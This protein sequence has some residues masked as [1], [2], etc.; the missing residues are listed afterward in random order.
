MKVSAGSA[1]ARTLKAASFPDQRAQSRT[2]FPEINTQDFHPVKIFHEAAHP[3]GEVFHVDPSRPGTAAFGEHQDRVPRIEQVMACV[4]GPPHFLAIA[5]SRDG[6][7]LRQVADGRLDGVAVE[8]A[9]LGEVPGQPPVLEQVAP[10][11]QHGIAEEHGVDQRQVICADEPASPVLPEMVQA[12]LP[13]RS[14]VAKPVAHQPDYD[15][16]DRDVDERSQMAQYGSG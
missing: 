15:A 3:V 6:D 2:S 13:E 8:V 4:E 10:V 16:D 12:L 5:S 9:A 11:R 14:E 1:F 7:A